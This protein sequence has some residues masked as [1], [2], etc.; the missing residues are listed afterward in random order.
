MSAYGYGN[1][2]SSSLLVLP[3]TSL[4]TYEFLFEGFSLYPRMIRGDSRQ[5]IYRFLFSNRCSAILYRYVCHG[6]CKYVGE[7]LFRCFAVVW[8]S[9]PMRSFLFHLLAAEESR[10]RK[11]FSELFRK[12]KVHHQRCSSRGTFHNLPSE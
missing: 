6:V 2:F 11:G 5:V 10:R 7:F 1:K 9:L 12:V 3:F 8:S 4:S